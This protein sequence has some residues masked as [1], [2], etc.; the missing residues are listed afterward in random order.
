MNSLS[1]FKIHVKS[2][3]NN[4]ETTH[5]SNLHENDDFAFTKIIIKFSV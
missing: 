3:N 2:G 5:K 1:L 4:T